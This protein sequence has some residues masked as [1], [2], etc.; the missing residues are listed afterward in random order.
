MAKYFN[1]SGR[2]CTSSQLILAVAVFVAAFANAKFYSAAI[3]AFGT[4]ASTWPFYL[5]LF[6]SIVAVL[7]LLLSAF[8]H[9]MLVKP[10]L[11]AVLMLSA[12]L[13]YFADAYG[14]V[15][16]A[17]MLANVLATDSA[18]AGDLFTPKL[19]LWIGLLGVLPSVAVWRVNLTFP[20]WIGETIARLKQA[21][22]AVAVIL[23]SGILFGGH[24]AALLREHREVTN[25]MIPAFA[26]LSAIRTAGHAIPAAAPTE[27]VVLGRD[28]ALPRSDGH[29]ELV[30][31]VVGETVRADHWGLNGYAR[32]TTPL[33]RKVNVLNFPD[34]WSCGTSTAISVPCMFSNLGHDRFDRSTATATDNALDILSRA[35]VSVL[36]RDNNSSSHG[37]AA[38]V[39]Y[40]D[41]RSPQRNPKCEER[42]CRDEGMLDGLQAYIDDQKGDILIVLHQMGN[43][44]PAYYKRYPKEFERFT[45]VCTTSDLGSCTPEQ[46]RN[47]YDNAI[48]YTDDFLSKV[49]ELLKAND[50]KYETAMFYLSDHGESLGEYGIYLHGAPYGLSPEAQRHVPAVMWFG[51]GIKHDLVT[52]SLEERSRRRWSQDNVFS[53]LL[54]FFEIQTTAYKASMDVLERSSIELS[55]HR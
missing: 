12:T 42:E 46:I 45:P 49:I 20:D 39:T 47:T 25:K 11:I 1:D 26:L 8:C 51:E 24:Y 48:L 19:L 2:A 40:Q 23:V 10:E 54:G 22:A 38:R 13:S 14:T 27:H 44:G 36:W 43:H 15:F 50:H 16:D 41:Y 53:T 4:D 32:D 6:I 52:T 30:I 37:V 9:R 28:A 55:D 29:R 3:E 35:G 21:G 33:L 34:F 17:Q 7:V 18:E 5:S 31:M